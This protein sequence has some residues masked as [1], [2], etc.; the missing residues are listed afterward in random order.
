MSN[1]KHVLI[2]DKA[3]SKSLEK[4][5]E[6]KNIENAKNKFLLHGIFT[7]FN[8]ENRNNRIYNADNFI[9][10]M[11]KM[12]EKRNKLGVLYGEFDHPDVFDI[13]GKNTS[14]VIEDI[15]HNVNENRVDGT[16][17]V[18][19]TTWG[20]EARAIINDG[21]PLFVSSRAAGV[22]SGQNV[23]LKELFT[24]DIVVDPGFSSARVSLNESMGY[25]AD[26]DV[27]YR[28][29]EMNDT[30]VNRLFND[31]KNDKNTAIDLNAMKQ[32]LQNEAIKIQEQI[33]A[34]VKNNSPENV[35]QLI[36]KYDTVNEEL[37]NVNSYLS[38][39]KTKISYLVN[40]NNKL[41]TINAE[42]KEELN[43]NTLYS[44]NLA[45]NI[46]NLS[47]V[48]KE[49]S[50]RLHVDEKMLEHVAEHTS[51]VIDFS[52]DIAKGVENTQTEL[53]IQG[54]F[55]DYLANENNI[56]QKFVENNARELDITQK[57]VENNAKELDITQ[58]FVEYNAKE[59]DITQK[60]VENNAKESKITQDFLDH[61]AEN[62]YNDSTFL[63]YIYEKVDGLVGYTREVVDSVKNTDLSVN[64]S[65]QKN[66]KSIYN[67]DSI[68][69]YLGLNEEAKFRINEEIEDIDNTEISNI[70]ETPVENV[71]QTIVDNDNDIDTDLENIDSE[72]ENQ[73]ENGDNLKNS[74]LSKLVKILSSD[75]TGIVIEVEDNK[76]I[77]QKSGS[78]ETVSFDEDEVLEKIEVINTEEKITE[79]VENVLAEIK[80]QKVLAN[81]EPHFFNFLSEKQLADFKQLDKETKDAIILAMNESEYYDEGDVLFIIKSVLETKTM[82]YE[83]R[84]I[85]NIP[86]DL[87]EAWN[88]LSKDQKQS[89][90]TESKYFNLLTTG[91]IVNFWKTQPF[92]KNVNGADAKI[93]KESLEIKSEDEQFS[94]EF[95]NAFLEK[96][97]N[98]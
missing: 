72:I 33:M 11:E 96:I 85:K 40:E 83:E 81:D 27:P 28:I 35:K 59:L 5:N 86:S 53:K 95:V 92:A 98:I 29:Y 4:V 54:S 12:W 44:N 66:S 64:E 79:T 42:L 16:I 63:N 23:M 88:N 77:I 37:N 65:A 51:A 76:V 89:T 97:Q 17:S 18:L 55:I 70:E 3:L 84:L 9:P 1:N 19:S 75:E 24:Y 80:K 39:L 10:V 74:L 36:E 87:K 67:I 26:D 47:D 30:H 73:D 50:E 82:S 43:E 14:H 52:K 41:K 48:Y 56:T 15:R 91:D 6:S 7:E 2:V 20:K 32:M 22:T 31:N 21:Y 68:D 61:V 90:I 8:V 62:V 34:N 13:T 49:I 25:K 93:I 69:E 94:D 58:K 46:K 45:S 38:Y 78:D 60:F 57:F 71:E